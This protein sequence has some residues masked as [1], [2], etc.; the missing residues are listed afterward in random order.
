MNELQIMS[1]T[2]R[3][4]SGMV[5]MQVTLYDG[6]TLVTQTV[7]GLD[8]YISLLR[9]AVK[10]VDAPTQVSL[11]IVPEG[12]YDGFVTNKA[13]TLGGIFY[14]PP[15]KH[16][17][18]LAATENEKR[19]SYYL[20][21]PGLVYSLICNE[22]AKRYM[23]CFAFKEWLGDKT[24]LYTYPFG[25]VSGVGD[26]CMGTIKGTCKTFADMRAY[27]EDSL[28]GVTNSDYLSQNQVRLAV[29]A[30]QHQFCDSIENEDEFPMDLLLISKSIS[31]VEE[32]RK[33]MLNVADTL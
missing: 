9:G 20:P 2:M 26:V 32:L 29:D 1:K 14:I 15:R 21:M 27:I 7:M 11:G 5:K 24:E 3:S 18:I 6:E 28:D 16:Q 10:R 13:G 22:G 25:N 17:F 8:D 30:T 4:R 23:R 12:L 33:N 31:T 19:K